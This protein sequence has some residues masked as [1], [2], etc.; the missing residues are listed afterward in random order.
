M[1]DGSMQHFHVNKNEVQH[2][3]CE[4]LI[5]IAMF[6]LDSIQYFSIHISVP[7]VFKGGKGTRGS[8]TY[9]KTVNILVILWIM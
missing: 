2:G 8:T 5:C 6:T 1:V 3:N 9:M 7:L 4:L